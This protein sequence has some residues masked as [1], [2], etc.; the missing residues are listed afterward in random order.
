MSMDFLHHQFRI[1][2]LAVLCITAASTHPVHAQSTTSMDSPEWYVGIGTGINFSKLHFSELD[3]ELYPDNNSNFSGVFSV[4]AEYDFGYS[5]SFA[6]RPQLSFL[7]CGGKLSNIGRGYFA[8]YDYPD[9]NPE[10]LE[11][12]IYQLKATYFDIRVPFIYQFGKSSWNLRPYVYVAPVIG[13]VTGGHVTARQEFVNG[14]FDGVRYKLSKANMSS[15]RFAGAVGLGA[16]WQIK[17]HDTHFYIGADVSYEFG[18]TDTYGSKEKDGKLN[19]VSFFPTTDH[20]YGSRK[21]SGIEASLTLGVPL[22]VFRKKT[23]IAIEPPTIATY[24][25]P[26]RPVTVIEEIEKACYTLDEIIDLM[27]KG[28]P[29]AGKTICA[30]DD[31]NFEFGKSSITPSSN[32]YLQKLAQ[33]LKRTNAIICVKGHTDNVGSEKFNLELSKQR[34]LE[35]VKYLH[36]YGVDESK[37]RYEYYGM[38]RPLT[39]N[40]TEEGRRLNRRVE[41][42]ILK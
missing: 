37:L 30:I 2:V 12:A 36:N 42:E 7:T 29:V 11:D 35:V 8:N 16:K 26:E 15:T 6:I 32:E 10:K 23:P 22:S 28:K 3:E 38:S 5:R 1:G 14:D 13:F 4:F 34:A 33:T 25:E 21:I 9:N 17:I 31:V 27:S 41:F 19:V 39:N 24:I 20:V 40:D 18:F